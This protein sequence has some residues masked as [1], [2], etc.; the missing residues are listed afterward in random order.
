MTAKLVLFDIDGTLILS[1]K[2][3]RKALLLAIEK[4]FHV[5]PSITADNTRGKTDKLIILETLKK[6]DISSKT[7][8]SRMDRTLN[9]YIG[10]LQNEYNKDDDAIIFPYV[11][12]LLSLLHAR[13]ETFLGLLT[14]NIE[15][16]ARIKLSPFNLNK[17]FPVGAFGSDAFYRE[18]LPEIA[19]KKAEINYNHVFKGENIIIIGDT[20]YDVLCGKNM[21][22]TSIAICRHP[23][24]RKTIE[25][26]Q[27]DYLFEG[28]EQT[29]K[30]VDTIISTEL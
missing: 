8:H 4:N 14:G 26:A 16:G 13:S 12:E 22:A 24:K 21:N 15:Q 7:I 18:E 9:D 17:Y 30:I 20:E 27:P 1:G 28:F 11:H 19:V 3:A 5:K 25:D 2:G 29:K 23:S 6:F 10:F